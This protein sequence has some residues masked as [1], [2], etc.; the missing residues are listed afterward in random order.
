MPKMKTNRAAAKRFTKTGGGK[1]KRSQAFRR[2]ILTSKSTK[3]KRHLRGPAYV[4]S[5][6]IRAVEERL[7]PNG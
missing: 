4:S 3:T 5:A 2:H 1:F 6:N 7:L